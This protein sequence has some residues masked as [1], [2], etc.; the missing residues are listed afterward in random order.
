MASH[1]AEPQGGDGVTDPYWTDGQVTVH[2]GDCRDV[3][4]HLE[5]ES[6]HAVVCDPPYD[7]TSGKKGGSGPASVN[8]N[9]PHGRA[10]ITAGFMGHSWDATGVAFDP[11]TWR[12]VMRVMKPGAYLLAFGG[13]RTYH[14]MACAIEDAGFDYLGAI[15]WIYASGMPKSLD[16]SKAIDKAAGAERTEVTG[17]KPGHEDFVTRTDDHAAGGRSE[18]WDRPW[19]ADAD[20]VARSH[21][22]LAPATEDAKRWQGW[23][24]GLK[25]AHEFICIARKPFKGT[26]AQN[27]LTH[28]TGAMNINGCRIAHDEPAG[29]P[30]VGQGGA[31]RGGIMGEHPSELRIRETTSASTAGRWPSNLVLS[32]SEFCEP[33]GVREVRSN[34]HHPASRGKGGISTSG[35][36]GQEGLA[37]R[38]SG[39]EPAEAWVCA[40]G[41]PVAEL[42]SQ[43]GVR[44]AGSPVRGTEPSH[45]GGKGIYG[46]IG[47]VPGPYYTDEGGAS[48]FF[49]T[50][51]FEPKAPSSERPKGDDGEQHSTVKPLDLVRWLVRLVTPPDG[52][53]LDCFAGSGTTGEACVIEGFRCVLVELEAVSAGLIVKRLDKPIQQAMFGEAI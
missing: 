33:L 5:A 44:P 17:V 35:H 18:G 30:S 1:T 36:A 53:V 50:F 26:Y 27:V 39:T 43:S 19:R 37:E 49:P 2:L 16:I 28:G 52:T 23:G 22:T 25:P 41:C 38:R 31:R 29:K 7:L 12:T 20:A 8:L 51:Q 21:L 34:G 46:E 3:L 47:R 15:D 40:P 4:P 14:R 42:D 24:T 32:H 45:S 6:V 9:S 48:R 13:D 10:R 11:E